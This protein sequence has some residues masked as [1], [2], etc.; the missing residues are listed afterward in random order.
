MSRM[1][2]SQVNLRKVSRRQRIACVKKLGALMET[3]KIEL[4]RVEV[5]KSLGMIER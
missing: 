3:R 2:S 5:D 4:L 1:M